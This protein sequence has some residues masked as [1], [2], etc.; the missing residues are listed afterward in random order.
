MLVVSARLL[1]RSRAISSPMLTSASEDTNRSSSIF[2]SSSAMGC[3][4]SRKLRA[5]GA[6]DASEGGV[7]ERGTGGSGKGVVIRG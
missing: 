6:E 3:S 2:A 5:M 1:A 7:K 4:N